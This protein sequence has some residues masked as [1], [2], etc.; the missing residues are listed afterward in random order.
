M[1]KYGHEERSEG[2]PDEE[3]G[4]Q[5]VQDEEREGEW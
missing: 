4:R 5:E 1:E 3:E 2:R